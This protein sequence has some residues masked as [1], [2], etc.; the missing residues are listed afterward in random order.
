MSTS[1]ENTNIFQQ[2]KEISDFNRKEKERLENLLA[3][4]KPNLIAV[5]ANCVQ[6]KR[7]VAFMKEYI[8]AKQE[9]ID[10]KFSEWVTSGDPTIPQLV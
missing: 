5:S 2:S 9:A 3:Q 6:A 8:S 10:K 4:F 1:N 7:V